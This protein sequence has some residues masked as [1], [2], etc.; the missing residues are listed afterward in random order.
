MTMARLHCAAARA[1][2]ALVLALHAAAMATG[3]PLPGGARELAASQLEP[4]DGARVFAYL[5]QPSDT[6]TTGCLLV[7]LSLAA[8]VCAFRHNNEGGGAV[9]T[10]MHRPRG[11]E[12]AG[13]GGAARSRSSSVD[14]PAFAFEMPSRAPPSGWRS[15]GDVFDL[16]G[17][18]LA[19]K[20]S[21][22]LGQGKYGV[23]YAGSLAGKPVAIK[24]HPE[25]PVT[26]EERQDLWQEILF[27]RR[28]QSLG[29]HENVIG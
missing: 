16:R 18:V 12:G 7:A 5:L 29:G 25:G 22:V 17:T 19:R 21:D 8:A 24:M 10:N 9:A 4:T 20:K 6:T 1:A 23:V 11:A 28:L 14:N 3:A 27:V 26:A 15:D 13:D 2:P